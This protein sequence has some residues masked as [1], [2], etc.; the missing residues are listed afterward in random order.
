VKVLAAGAAVIAIAVVL[1]LLSL[2]GLIL[3]EAVVLLALA[4]VVFLVE[5]AQEAGAVMD[6]AMAEILKER[7]DVER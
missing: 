6:A 1:A 3:L 5:R 2:W 4:A 7:G